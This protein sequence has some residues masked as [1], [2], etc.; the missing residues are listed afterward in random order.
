[1][2]NKLT[3]TYVDNIKCIIKGLYEGD[4]ELLYKEFSIFIPSARFMPQYKMGLF[5]G[6]IRYFQKTGK[7]Y[8]NLLPMM[9]Q[10]ID[11]SRYSSVEEICLSEFTHDVSLGDDVDKNFLSHLNWYSGHRLEG[12][13]IELGDHQIRAINHL[14]KNH[15]SVLCSSTS[16]GKTLI[17]GALCHKVKSFGKT[18]IVVPSKDLCKQTANELTLFGLDVGIVGMGLREFEHNVIVC[19]WQ[20]INSIEKT[21]IKDS[22]EK[23]LSYDELCQLKKDVVCLIFDE[24]HQATGNHIKGVMEST[25]KSVPIRW[26]L[27]GTVPKEK[28]DAYCLLTAIGATLSDRIEAKEL[29]DKGFLSQCQVNCIQLED[30][31][32]FMD[33]ESEVAYLY[34][35]D[36]R[37]EFISNLISEIVKKKNNT[38][39]L[40]GRIETGKI[41]EKIMTNNGINAI[42][43]HG[44]TKSKKRFEEYESIKSEN[45]KCLIC[46]AQIAS[47]GLNIPRLFNV[48]LL[49]I[50]KSF[51]RCIQSIGRGLRKAKDKDF[52]SI[53]DI[54]SSTKYSKKHLKERIKYYI[55]AQYPYTV[56]KINKNAWNK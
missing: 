1:M 54:S 55:E 13:P 29:Q 22:D 53:Y 46:T 16:S 33:Y 42:F 35:D 21:K 4:I 11:M 31:N 5:D 6:Y 18:V 50:G 56:Y 28:A 30:K 25:F 26:G 3:I 40:V 23:K 44:S 2:L 39:I 24:C 34:T 12:Q 47:T 14:L 15:R 36:K 27:T 9:L 20:T 45:N 37:L 43:L 38:L 8:I 41:L 52:V 48:V 32:V 19:T 17:C 49:D 10:K 7:T 51:T